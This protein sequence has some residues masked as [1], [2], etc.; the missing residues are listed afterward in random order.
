MKGKR[1]IVHCCLII[2]TNVDTVIQIKSHPEQPHIAIYIYTMVTTEQINYILLVIVILLHSLNLSPQCD[3]EMHET[4][5]SNKL[6]S[7]PGSKHL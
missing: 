1:Q 2:Y 4:W 5:Y 3:H 6:S 7:V